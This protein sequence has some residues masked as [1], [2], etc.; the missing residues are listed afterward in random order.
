MK[1]YA[2]L[3]MI[4]LA[5][6]CWVCLPQSSFAESIE[7]PPSLKSLF[8]TSHTHGLTAAG[9]RRVSTDIIRQRTHGQRFVEFRGEMAYLPGNTVLRHGF[10]GPDGEPEEYEAVA[11]QGEFGVV[12]LVLGGIVPIPAKIGIYPWDDVVKPSR[13]YLVRINKDQHERLMAYIVNARRNKGSFY[14]FTDNCVKFA[15]GAAL[16]IGLKV[17]DSTVLLPPIFVNWLKFINEPR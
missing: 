9:A 13:S 7:R 14:L 6:L 11:Y 4:L 5:G 15:R 10:L 8:G 1:R 2:L 16:A 17:P 3:S 12:G